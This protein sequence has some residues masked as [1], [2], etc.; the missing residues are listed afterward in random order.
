[1]ASKSCDASKSFESCHSV[2]KL[3]ATT[4]KEIVIQLTPLHV[5]ATENIQLTLAKPQGQSDFG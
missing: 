2:M 3:T 1:M 5:T 4:K